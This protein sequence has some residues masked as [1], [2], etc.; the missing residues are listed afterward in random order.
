[1]AFE[2]VSNHSCAEE[3]GTGP[4]ACAADDDEGELDEELITLGIVYEF[5]R[6]EGLPFETAAG[7]YLD[8]FNMLT[9]NDQPSANIMT[10]GDIFGSGR[11]FS[12]APQAGSGLLG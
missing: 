9:G 8:T 2:Y 12:G 11:H 5:L 3:T 7:D 10:A 4:T 6:G 1:M